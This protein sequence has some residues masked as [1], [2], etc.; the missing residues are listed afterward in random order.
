VLIAPLKHAYGKLIE[1]MMAARNNHIHKE[2]FLHLYPSGREKVF[3]LEDI[4]NGFTGAGLIPID[5]VQ[6]LK[7]ITF[8]LRTPTPSLLVEGSISSAFQP[9]RDPRQQDYKVR[10]LQRSLQKKRKEHFLAV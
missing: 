3:A 6:V 5:Q 9:V 2:D 10:S 7:K 8:Q 1:G 4:C